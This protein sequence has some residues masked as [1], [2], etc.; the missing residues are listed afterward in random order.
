MRVLD[1]TGE[2][3]QFCGRMLAG[4]GA[5]VVKVEPPDGDP[6]RR[7]GPW[8]HDVVSPET[9]LRWF[10]L[11]VGKRS[12]TLD[13]ASFPGRDIF[14]RLAANADA[15]I[16]S[17]APGRL[18]EFG[19]SPNDLRAANP[20][21][22]VTSISGYGQDGPYRDVPWS[23]LTVLA[24][25]SLLSLSGD[26]DRAP[27][28]MSTPQSFFHVSMQATIGTLL[29]LY[30]RAESGHGQHVD[31]SAQ[32]ALTMSLEGPGPI[33]NAWRMAGEVQRRTGRFREP[34]PGFRIQVV[35]PCKDGYIA[36]AAILGQA[37]P[38]WL[39]ALEED[40]MAGDLADERW[41]TASFVGTEQPGQWVPNPAE[42]D[43]VYEVVTAWTRTRTKAE[44]A[45]AARR[46]NFLAGSQNTVL[47]VLDNEQLQTRGFFQEVAHPDLDATV[48]YLGAPFRMTRTPWQSGPRPPLL[49]EHTAAVLA[50]VGIGDDE[51]AKLQAEGVV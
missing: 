22:V 2:E 23:D 31:V 39:A 38:T 45:E 34:S 48:T 21:L 42:L 36:V 7:I 43:H 3:G 47:D 50:E 41:L 5:D 25:S 13:L 18:A 28:R 19:L 44:I 4:L 29:A 51:H 40:G 27:L 20:A 8:Y 33:V 11:N 1:L 14:R 49:G 17:F 24:M 26:E 35:L 6:V 9:S 12:V 46:H 16:E 32:E 37:L 10:A 15:V 30:G